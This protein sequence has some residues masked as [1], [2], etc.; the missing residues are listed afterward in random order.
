MDIDTFVNQ[1]NNTHVDEDGYYGAQ[2][3]DLVAKYARVVVGCPSFPTG[4]GGAEGLYR[5]FQAPI[6]Q[7]FDRVNGGYR[8]GDVIV[9]NA[10]FSPPY[11]HTA[12]CLG[13]DGTTLTVLEQNGNNPGGASY[14]KTRSLTGVSGALRP[15]EGS[16]DKITKEDLDI[17][18]IGHSEIGGWNVDEVHSGKYD[19][20]FLGWVGEDL[21]R[22]IRA[23][24]TAG[25]PYRVLKRK[26]QSAFNTVDGLLEQ[27]KVLS[28]RPTVEDYTK[29]TSVKDELVKVQGI[30]DGEI[31]RLTKENESLKAQVG[32][33][34]KW[35]TFK[36]LIRELIK[37]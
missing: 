33:N 23:Q 29:L 25:D 27:V 1:T 22:F 31:D 9:W 35:E 15:K 32:D 5:L 6:P 16:M 14:V 18:R 13:F 37:G 34:S 12:L 36:A 20:Q 2:C 28:Q 11:G 24:W 21:K 3:W 30:K 4:S 7:Y 26:W 10:N 17:L 8:K 19:A